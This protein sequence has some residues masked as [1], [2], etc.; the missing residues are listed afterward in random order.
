MSE[1][2]PL[3]PEEQEDVIRSVGAILLAEAPES[4]QELRVSFRS[5]IGVDTATFEVVMADGQITKLHPPDSA[6]E[7]MTE[8]RTGMYQEGKG[9]WFTA[10]YVIKPPG[11]YN[12]DFDYDS[13]PNFFPPLNAGLYSLD[14]DY[15]PRSPE[16]TPDWLKQKL[17]EAAA[18]DEDK[19]KD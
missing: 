2:V 4:W 8:L 1:P 19:P 6:M 3:S 12:V 5:T 13:Q 7:K 11:R 10:T 9:S 15:F 18:E 16:N 14:F 17:E